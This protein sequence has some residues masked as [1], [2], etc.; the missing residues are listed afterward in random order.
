MKSYKIHL[1]R[2]GITEAN[3]SGRYIGTTDLP[4]TEAGKRELEELKEKID[5]PQAE[6]FYTSPKLRCIETLRILYPEAQ[7]IAVD[8][9]SELNFGRFEG[10]SAY[11]LD[12]DPDYIAWT[13]GKADAPPEGESTAELTARVAQGFTAVVHHLMSSGKSEAVI[14][15]HGGV[16]M[17]ILSTCGLPQQPPHMW[18]S[19]PGCGY[20]VRITPSV[21]MRSGVIEIDSVIGDY[22]Y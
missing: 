20:T 8:E 1:I 22:K 3:I 19:D 11:E 9:L 21:F 5:Y 10:M 16:I 4:L 17:N 15:T 2:H 7:A 18:R 13:S 14:I 6:L 12:G